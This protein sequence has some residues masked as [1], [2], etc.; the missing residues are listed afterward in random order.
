[1]IAGRTPGERV[2]VV[3]VTEGGWVKIMREQHTD[4]WY[5]W[6]NFNAAQT[7]TVIVPAPGVGLALY[8]TDILFT[9]DTL[10]DLFLE[11]GAVIIVPPVYLAAQGGWSGQFQTPIRWPTNTAITLTSSAIGNHSV[12]I[13]GYTQP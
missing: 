9:T 8:V 10:M 1:M 5:A 7:D 13:M 12:K 2:H 4:A 6:G 3:E 11:S